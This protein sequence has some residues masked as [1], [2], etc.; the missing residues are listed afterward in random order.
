MTIGITYEGEIGRLEASHDNPQQVVEL[1]CTD[2]RFVERAAAKKPN[3]IMRLF[4]GALSFPRDWWYGATFISM[5][6]GLFEGEGRAATDGTANTMSRLIRTAL[7][8]RGFAWRTIR[9]VLGHLTHYPELWARQGTMLATGVG[10]S[11]L[12][13]PMSV[14]IPVAVI[15]FVLAT[16]GAIARAVDNGANS[17]AEIVIAAAIGESDPAVAQAVGQQLQLAVPQPEDHDLTSEEEEYILHVLRGVLD[18]L[19]NPGR[20]IQNGQRARQRTVPVGQVSSMRPRGVM[21]SIPQGYETNAL[22]VIGDES[23][24]W[25]SLS[26]EQ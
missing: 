11:I 3:F 24:R 8:N 19:E 18:C 22:D 7:A 2:P 23:A 5:R 26:R 25:R 21:G 16:T 1:V 13:A 4:N 20:Y 15:N 9:A 6:F 12:G 14:T 10:L 17:F